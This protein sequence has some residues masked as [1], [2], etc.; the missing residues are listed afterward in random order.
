MLYRFINPTYSFTVSNDSNLVH[1][2]TVNFSFG[3]R[4]CSILSHLAASNHMKVRRVFND[5]FTQIDNNTNK[6]HII[7]VKPQMYDNRDVELSN[8]SKNHY[9]CWLSSLRKVESLYFKLLDRNIPNIAANDILPDCTLDTIG[10]YGTITQWVTFLQSI[11]DSPVGQEINNTILK[12]SRNLIKCFDQKGFPNFSGKF[13]Y[14]CCFIE[15]QLRNMP[16]FGNYYTNIDDV[17]NIN[18]RYSDWTA[19]QRWGDVEKIQFVTVN[20]TG[21]SI[22]DSII[23]AYTI[24]TRAILG[25]TSPSLGRKVRISDIWKTPNYENRE[26][27]KD[28]IIGNPNKFYKEGDKCNENN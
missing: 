1:Y 26:I 19:K 7:V 22:S 17:L 13:E 27:V 16:N 20:K 9:L 3:R 21:C 10:I 15:A 5:N 24:F 28:G 2:I 23:R 14:I 8:L 25:V 4:I 6:K 11:V 18:K 12:L